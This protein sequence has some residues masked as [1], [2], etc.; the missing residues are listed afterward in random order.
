MFRPLND[1]V[2][3]EP[4]KSPDGTKGG[5]LLPDTA[6]G[7]YHGLRATVVA[8]G[9]GSFTSAGTRV[10]LD[11][12]VGDLVILRNPGPLLREDDRVF[13]VVFERD[14]LAVVEGGSASPPAH[15]DRDEFSPLDL[16]A[17]KPVLAN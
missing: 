5:L 10:P 14:I 17:V 9:P 7:N 16:S 15:F 11:L 8:V 4:V 3:V 13:C 2:V 1:Q 6:K 12:K